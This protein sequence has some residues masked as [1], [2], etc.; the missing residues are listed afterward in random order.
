MLDG[1]GRA[2][3]GDP[4]TNAAAG[5]ANAS[6]TALTPA[7]AALLARFSYFLWLNSSARGPIL[8]AW[9][10]GRLHWARPLLDQ[11]A[12]PPAGVGKPPSSSSFSA[13][14]AAAPILLAGASIACTSSGFNPP[15]PH[16]QSYISATTAEGM[17]ILLRAPGVFDSCY[18]DMA[19]VVWR[20]EIGASKA[21]LAA[22]GNLGSL[23]GRYAGL[24]WREEALSGK[25]ARACNAGRNPLQPGAHDGADASPHELL[26]VKVKAPL[27]AA[28]WPSARAGAAAARAAAATRALA[29]PA[30]GAEGA[31]A[32]R[33]A[34]AAAASANQWVDGGEEEAAAAAACRRGRRCFDW[35]FY[36]AAND[37]DLGFLREESATEA[38]AAAEAWAQ[39]EEQGVYEGR[40]HRWTC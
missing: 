13:A 40:P 29:F 33:G 36:Y 18:A 9:A 39:F 35:R 20:S 4:T 14:V 27:L 30:G 38:E 32:A 5:N 7:A 6:A 31:A 22:G 23:M 26:F 19:D 2:S 3:G 16:V 25:G 21:I 17:A 12:P 24:D 10:R 28:G 8:P 34:A 11:L 37:R 15:A 1:E